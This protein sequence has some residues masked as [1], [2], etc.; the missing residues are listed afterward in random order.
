MS[1][2][3]YCGAFVKVS[4]PDLSLVL[5]SKSQQFIEDSSISMLN[6]SG[7]GFE[8][9]KCL[10]TSLCICSHLRTVEHLDKT[11][12]STKSLITTYNIHAQL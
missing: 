2:S 5:V 8:T 10:L 9:K 3:G 7:S 6:Q 4:C 1:P 11:L 12:M